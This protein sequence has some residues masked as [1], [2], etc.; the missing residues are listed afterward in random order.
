ML[1]RVSQA[2]LQELDY[3]TT[4]QELHGQSSLLSG[5]GEGQ[6]CVCS[7][8]T[9]P[10]RPRQCGLCLQASGSSEGVIESASEDQEGTLGLT[11]E[12]SEVVTKDDSETSEWWLQEG[13]PLEAKDRTSDFQEE[14]ECGLYVHQIADMEA[15]A[16]QLLRT[17]DFQHESCEQLLEMLPYK[18]RKRHRGIL[19]Q[20]AALYLVL[21]AYSYGGKYGVT[22]RTQQLPHTIRYLNK[23]LDHWQSGPLIRSSLVINCNSRC[24]LHRDV[25]NNDQQYDNQIVGTGHYQGGRL[26]IECCPHEDDP[27]QEITWKTTPQGRQVPG[28]YHHIHHRVTTFKPQLWHEPETWS[29]YRRVLTG[30][31]SRGHQKLEPEQRQQLQKLGFHLPPKHEPRCRKQNEAYSAHEAQHHEGP[32]HYG[33]Q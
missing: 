15:V 28:R 17:Q 9:L 25:Y 6:H 4:F 27:Q 19:G 30:Y 5:F 23:Y 21:G 10:N 3:T 16:Q 1:D 11:S 26:W 18:S 22:Q 32:D 14:D 20:G 33:S 24:P 8:V 12:S 13:D 7:D 31:T 29:G 2:L